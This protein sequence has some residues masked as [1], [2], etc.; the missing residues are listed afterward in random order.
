[1]KK[2]EFEAILAEQES[3]DRLTKWNKY[4]KRLNF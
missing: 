1:M 3:I 2:H 4:L